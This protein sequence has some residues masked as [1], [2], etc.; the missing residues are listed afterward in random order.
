MANKIKFGLKNVYYSVINLV[1]NVPQYATPVPIHGA[2]NLSLSPAG[3]KYEFYA[4]DMP[5]FVTNSNAGYEGTLEIARIPDSFAVDVMGETIDENG[6]YIENSDAVPKNFALMFEFSGDEHATR[7]VLYN[8]VAA[9]PNLEGTTKGKTIEAKTETLNITVAPAADTYDVKAKLKPGDTGY[10]TF[11]TAVYVKN[12]VTNTISVASGTFNK[13]EPEDITIDA[14][15]TDGTNKVK[16]VKINGASIGGAN[17]SYSGVD[18]TILKE[19]LGTLANG[20]YAVSVE[21]IKGNAI[22]Y[23]ITVTA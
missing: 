4:D 14:T 7:H 16:D 10:D 21:F 18:A 9:R 13:G 17:M 2:V 19:Y 8:V 15:S 1:N 3:E 20:T 12:A 23:I 5:Y 6:A 11:F 22:A